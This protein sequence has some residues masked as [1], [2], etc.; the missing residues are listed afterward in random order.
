MKKGL[1]VS[2]FVVIYSVVTQNEPQIQVGENSRSIISGNQT[3][4]YLLYIPEGYDGKT[5]LP[6]VFLFHGSGMTSQ[7]AMTTTDL[8]KVA[9]KK[10]FIIAAPQSILP[11]WNTNPGA[12]EINYDV[13]L[14]KDLIRQISSKVAIDQKEYMPLDIQ[15]A[16]G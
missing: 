10:K 14:V 16:H 13:E 3:R 5:N 8:S 6:L 12:G 15:V 2:G 7:Q 4:Q 9:D 11:Y 1:F